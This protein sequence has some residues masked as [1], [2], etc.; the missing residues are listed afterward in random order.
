VNGFAAGAR[1]GARHLIRGQRLM[2]RH[3]RWYGLGLL[4]ALITL[5]IYGAALVALALWV[6]DLAAWATPFA[7]GWGD[8]WRGAL[9]TLLAVLLVAAGLLLAVLTF[10]AVTLLIGDPFYEALSER[11]EQAAG[12]LPGG[13]DVPLWRGLWRSLRANVYVLL[14]ALAFAVAL[15]V[16]SF[17]PVLG[18]TV[19]PVLGV[20]VSGF[21]LTVEL[22]SVAMERRGVPVRERVRLLRSHLGLALGFGVP[23]VLCFLVPLAAVFLMPGAVAGATL[24]VRELTGAPPAPAAT[25]RPATPRRPA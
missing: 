22:S 6:G 12:G 19:V 4:P 5:V 17:V 15:F 23:L 14:R 1:Q 2:A 11:V 21:F 7:D 25:G 3:G 9:R 13:P 8:A 24:L 20:A 18:Q 16:L 10:T